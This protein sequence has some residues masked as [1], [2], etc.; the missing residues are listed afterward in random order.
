MPPTLKPK[1]KERWS[2]RLNDDEAVHK[3]YHKCLWLQVAES[4]PAN[5]ESYIVK[6]DILFI[7]YYSTVLQGLEDIK[8]YD[9]STSQ[10]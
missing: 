6:S 9:Q 2:A 3:Y 10:T 4:I 1:S 5:A 8:N 7:R